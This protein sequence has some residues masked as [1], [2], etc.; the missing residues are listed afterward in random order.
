M[1]STLKETKETNASHDHTKVQY[2]RKSA[3]N[4][5]KSVL[6]YHPQKLQC[7]LQHFQDCETCHKEFLQVLFEHH[8]ALNDY[9]PVEEACERAK[10]IVDIDEK[11][12]SEI[13]W[14]LGLVLTTKDGRF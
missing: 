6:E 5:I 9:R 10:I 11:V 14:D 4:H 8:V 3:A 2:Q 1:S 7:L 13:G 12:L